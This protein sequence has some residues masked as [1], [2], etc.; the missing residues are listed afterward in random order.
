ML[1]QVDNQAEA[2][3]LKELYKMVVQPVYETLTIEGSISET[4]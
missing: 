1:L 3:L 2:T 4:L